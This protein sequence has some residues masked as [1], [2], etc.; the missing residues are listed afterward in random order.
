MYRELSPGIVQHQ[1]PRVFAER[2]SREYC[3]L[4]CLLRV[5]FTE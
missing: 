3:L 5:K 1:S 2:L 4:R